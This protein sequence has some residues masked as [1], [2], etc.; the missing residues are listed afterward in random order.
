[1][2]Q[3]TVSVVL[4]VWNGEKYLAEAIHSMTSQ[5]FESFELLV[6]DNGSTDRTRAIA[7]EFARND[8]RILVL[9]R[10]HRGVAE[11]S[12]AGI[13]AARGRYVAR[14][15]ADDISHPLRLQ[16][17]IAFLDANPGCVAVGSHIR[18]IDAEGKPIGSWP[19]PE[20]HE[21]IVDRMMK[22]SL[23]LAHPSAVMRTEAVRSAGGYRP[24]CVPAEDL[25]LWIRMS[26]LGEFA[27][28]PE[29]LLSYRRHM[30]A[31]GVRE[32]EGQ[33]IM[34]SSLI[35]TARRNRGLGS[36]KLRFAAST[37]DSR[38]DYHFECARIALRSGRR[39]A[40]IK[41]AWASIVSAPLWLPSYAALAACALPAR[42][43]SGIVR[44]IKRL[45]GRSDA[46]LGGFPRV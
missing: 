17:Q 40:A 9:A 31:V 39:R 4:P 44:L 24:I 11:A 7:L 18:I 19:L 29:Q 15:D 25:D 46:L 6:V 30:D 41:H 14:M 12:N 34:I 22:G 45:H 37:G 21:E 20:H 8:G 26:E 33:T 38:C 3:P 43:L 36:V 32:R 5:T 28:L 27:N 16:K 1:M 42:A 35:N 2:V 13:D 23:C 10:E